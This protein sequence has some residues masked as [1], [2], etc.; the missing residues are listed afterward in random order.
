MTPVFQSIRQ[1]YAAEMSRLFFLAAIVGLLTAVG[2]Y[3]YHI[4]IEWFHELFQERLAHDILGPLIGGL[5]LV[6]A[7][8]LAGLLVGWIMQRF[9]GPERH[10]GVT[11]VVES[12]ALAGGRLP[13]RKMPFKGIASALSLGAGAPVGPEDPSVQIGS[14]IA[15][16][17]GQRVRISEDQVRLLV[18]AG[19]ASAVSAAFSAPIAGVFFALEI[20]LNG[21]FTT[22]G[23]GAIMLAS[24]IASAATQAMGLHLEAV[25]PL[26]YILSSPLEIAL[27][28]P[29]GIG[30]GVLAAGVIRLIYW[31]RDL[32]HDRVRIPPMYK[33]ALAGALIGLVGLALPEILGPGREIMNAVLAGEL[34]F[35]F[36]VLL[37]IGGVKLALTAVALGGGFVGGMFAPSLFIGT[38]FGAAYGQ[39]MRALIPGLDPQ[40]YAI[41]GM[42]GLMAG[43][44]RAPFTAIMIVFELTR[45]YRLILPMMLT[46]ILCIVV[47]ERFCKEGLYTFGL[48]RKGI[49]LRSGM[50]IDV[51]QSVKVGEVMHAPPLTI[52]EDASL[53]DL[54]DTLREANARSLS[55]LDGHGRLAGVVTL[56]DL[57]RAYAEDPSD[58]RRV[59]DI[60]SRNLVT[61]F[62]D[63]S[64]W[65]ALAKMGAADV[66]RLPVIDAATG[67][68]VGMFRRQNIVRAYNM[69]LMKRVEDQHRAEQVRLNT[70]TGA[71][72]VELHVLWNSPIAHH[73]IKDLKLPTESVIASVRREGRLIVPHGATMILPNDV[74]TVVAGPE[75]EAEL[76]TLVGG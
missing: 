6:V 32:W 63:E 4:L 57:Q 20:I 66:G 19:G 68:L 69:Q 15:S 37:L 21:T 51:M 10:H 31:Q 46:T 48:V 61:T 43:V 33:T 11:A 12:V 30:M 16:W 41:A 22:G 53:S 54:R 5:G 18:A 64:V 56:R 47:A 74:L 14:N 36:A 65:T 52:R 2:I 62:T 42:A 25:G 71:H 75:C 55:V 34:A 29:L 76:K 59:G 73:R 26:N 45:D 17:L 50:E 35:P 49:R 3:I 9:V 72:V 60:C 23:F 40:S 70:L 1:I 38:M 8:A 28:V 13:Y 39:A 24:V 44:L 7:L 67:D 58:T 27:Y